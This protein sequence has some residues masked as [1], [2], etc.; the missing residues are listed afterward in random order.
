MAPKPTP[1]SLRIGYGVLADLK[2]RLT[3][4]RWPDEVPNNNWKYGT[5][6]PYPRSLV[7]YWREGYDWRKQ[8]AQLNGGSP[9]AQLQD[10]LC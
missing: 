5:D 2:T 8:E 7:E 9:R 3:R 6:L 10:P 1:F 4:V